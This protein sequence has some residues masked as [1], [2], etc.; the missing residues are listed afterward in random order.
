MRE[1]NY[2][3]VKFIIPIFIACLLMELL[4]RSIPNDYRN[5][6]DYLEIK[7]DSIEVL[8]LGGSHSLHGFNPTYITLKG[9][10]AGGPSQSLD[11]D[12]EILKKYESD[13]SNLKYIILPI[14]YPSLFE[15]I[16]SSKEP[17]R[18]KNYLLYYNM[19]TSTHLPYYTEIFS[20]TLGVNLHRLYD[21]YVNKS[22]NITC[23]ALGWDFSYSIPVGSDKFLIETSRFNAATQT[24]KSD[25]YFDEMV[26]ALESIIKFGKKYK[27]DLIL[28]TLPGY[29]CYRE[30][31]NEDQMNRTIIKATEIST[32]NENCHYFNFLKD[33]TFTESDFYDGD[34]L[35]ADGAKKLTLKIDSIIMSKEVSVH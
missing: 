31:L 15:K 29:K 10:N 34:H 17:W 35:N 6:R 4:L 18:I 9:Y 25:Q 14:S 3:F 12:L 24:I 27:I 13:W 8:F 23:T 16:K 30:F 2:R 28:V 19:K 5:K 20:N 7:S 26:T 21:Y 11:Y 1:F 22:E 32:R 33:Q